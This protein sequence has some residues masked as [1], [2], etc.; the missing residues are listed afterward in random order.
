MAA[1]LGR[2]TLDLVV[3]TAGYT[4]PL[5]AAERRTTQAAQNMQQN[6]NAASA[7]VRGYIGA[8]AGMMTVHEAINKMDTYTRLQNRLKL[9]TNSQYELARATEA[10]YTIAQKTGSAWD[11][12]AL[13]YQRFAEN[14]KKYHL[15]MGAIAGVTETV[16]KSIAISGG[17]A[18]SA[19]A[20]LMQFGQALATGVLR[21][22]EFNSVNEQAPGLLKAIAQ[23]LGVTQGQ[24]RAMANEG[25]ITGDK[26]VEAL[27]KSKDYIDNSFNKTDFTVAQSWQM[28]TNSMTKFVGESG[29]ASG[30]SHGIAKSLQFLAKH[31]DDAVLIGEVA[32]VFYGT[33]MVA[34]LALSARASIANAIAA[35]AQ[36]NADLEAL[37]VAELRAVGEMRASRTRLLFAQEEVAHLL[38]KMQVE[39]AAGGV[40]A[41]TTAQYENAM[42][43]RTAAVAANAEATVAANRAIAASTAATQA[44]SVGLMAALGGPVGLGLTVAALAG[45]YLLMRDNTDKATSSFSDHAM[46]VKELTA[47]YNELDAV[48]KRVEYRSAAQEVQDYGSKLQELTGRMTFAYAQ[49]Q[50]ISEST[51]RLAQDFLSGK[52]S[53]SD[54]AS[55]MQKA[56]DVSDAAKETIDKLALE[57]KQLSKDLDFAKTKVDAFSTAQNNAKTGVDAHTEAIKKQQ[58]AID[59][60]KEAY[61]K[62]LEKFK[63]QQKSA[64]FNA[65][66]MKL[67]IMDEGKRKV[68]EDWVTRYGWDVKQLRTQTAIND[69][70]ES[71]KQYELINKNKQAQDAYNKAQEKQTKEL[72]KQG[73]VLIGI[74]GNS[75]RGTGAHLDVRYGGGREGRVT[76]EH[77]ARLQA[78][79]E[80]LG[81]KKI[82]SDYGYRRQ[83][84]AGAST[85]HKGI[86]FAMPVGTPITTSVGVKNVK[87]W[88][89][90]KGGGYVSTVTFED[91]VVLKLLHQSPSVMTK[92]QSKG[93]PTGKDDGD[94]A[95]FLKDQT[96]RLEK[97]KETQERLAAEYAKGADKFIIDYKKRQEEI[98]KAGLPEAE[99]TKYSE[100]NRERLNNEIAAFKLSNDKKLEERKAFLKTDRQ[101]LIDAAN[102]EK[103]NIAI[104]QTLNP[105]QKE[106]HAKF[107]DAKLEYELDALEIKNN[108]A[109]ADMWSFAQTERD[110]IEYRYK[111]ELDLARES[112][113]ELKDERINAL[114]QQRDEELKALDRRNQL[115]ILDAQ[116]GY[117]FETKLMLQKYAIERQQIMDNHQISQALKE[118]QLQKNERDQFAAMEAARGKIGQRSMDAATALLQRKN[119]TGYAE[120]EFQNQYSAAMG[121]LQTDYNNATAGINAKDPASGDYIIKSAQERYELLK[122]AEA[123]FQEAKLAIIKDY[124]DKQ[125]TMEA[126]QQA[127][128]IDGYSRG[129]GLLID[130]AGMYGNKQSETYRTMLAAQKGFTLASAFLNAKGAIMSAWNDPSNVTIW[131][132]LASVASVA[133]QT[134]SIMSAIKG[135][136]MPGFATG[137]YTGAG[138]KYQPAGLV[139][140]GE[141]VWSQ[142]DI[143][144]WGGVGIVESMR[145]GRGYSDGGVVGIKTPTLPT[146]PDKSTGNVTVNVTVNSDGSAQV[147]QQGATVLGEQLKNAVLA[148]IRQEKRQGGILA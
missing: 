9:V 6:L 87:T 13:V 67:G 50:M 77:L 115:Q 144:R 148:V 63:D 108:K 7:A 33:K 36:R 137:G 134:E 82:T 97:D 11:S 71:L 88:Q 106:V 46:K 34:S 56:T 43:A 23:G 62:Y 3:R 4:T 141:I 124:A 128:T 142:D 24:L 125:A 42:R 89:D 103:A 132:K 14:A 72:E 32:A 8:V 53:A 57:H 131:Q 85:F 21:G 94:L 130:L 78:G 121:G 113:D 58:I 5:D 17:S 15:T 129:F 135:V 61:G 54:Y 59:N 126:Q 29:K 19:E 112:N 138:G 122:Q 90:D 69:R 66:L 111:Y 102:D 44:S 41:A 83:P 127:N 95:T 20:A 73:K 140:A 26:L 139:H 55:G 91:G 81:K 119:P 51:R 28:L 12:T 76:D 133:M 45:T 16:A 145:L 147:T 92:I 10:T 114:Q 98:D 110:Q 35:S 118:A 39:R 49:N 48:Q 101:L 1:S 117:G 84:V 86:D 47:A 70:D 96:E 143:K 25:Q 104:D 74:S 146:L 105:K 75:G 2:L 52:I 27:Q 99:H 100:A 109:L 107:V 79:G 65:E 93:T 80:S 120:W 136:M 37:R 22:E 123:D 18:A 30:A 31:I 64:V 40:T 60:A 38:H 116:Q 68:Y